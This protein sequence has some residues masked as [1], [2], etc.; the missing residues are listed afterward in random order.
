M[1]RYHNLCIYLLYHYHHHLSPDYVCLLDELQLFLDSPIE[2]YNINTVDLFLYRLSNVFQVDVL[3]IKSNT[4]DCWFE[5]LTGNNNENPKKIYFVK[6][7]SQ[8]IDQVVLKVNED[9][10][11]DSITITHY[12]E[13]RKV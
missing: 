9:N 4:E 7:L 8:H 10:S 13:F 1:T 2:Y 11:D 12:L 3:I 5:D 6:T